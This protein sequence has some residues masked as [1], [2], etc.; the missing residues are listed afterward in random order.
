MKFRDFLR[1]TY[2]LDGRELLH[3]LMI[4]LIPA[5]LIVGGIFLGVHVFGSQEKSDY[6]RYCAERCYRDGT[7]T[8]MVSHKETKTEVICKCAYTIRAAK[9]LVV[10]TRPGEK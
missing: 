9:S 6:Q 10:F 7:L 1:D 5:G 3:V 4:S 8:G 2:W